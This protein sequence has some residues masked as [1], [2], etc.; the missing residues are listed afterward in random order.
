MSS[1]EWLT[2]N[3]SCYTAHDTR[4][5]ARDIGLVLRTTPVESPTATAWPRRSSEP[6]SATTLAS[7]TS[8]TPAPCSNRCQSGS[9]TI[10]GCI[11]TAHSTTVHPASLSIAQPARLRQAFRGQ[12]HKACSKVGGE[13]APARGLSAPFVRLSLVFIQNREITDDQF[14]TAVGLASSALR[15]WHVA[16]HQVVPVTP[17]SFAG[18]RWNSS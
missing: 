8:P 15:A 18:R 17:M 13:S 2:D 4:R 16:R 12:Q 14:W 11:R 5:F 10:I 6:S 1:I 7:A 9:I 3:G